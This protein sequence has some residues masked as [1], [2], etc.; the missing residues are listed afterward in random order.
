[1]RFYLLAAALAWTLVAA[2][3][4]RA[5]DVAVAGPS[6]VDVSAFIRDD[7]IGALKLSPDGRFYAATIPGEGR[8]VLAIVR[9]EDHHAIGMFSLGEN[10][11]VHDFHWV[12]PTRVVISMAEKIGL[13][14]Q[15]RLTGN[16]YAMDADGDDP[17]IL[18]GQD[19]QEMSAGSRIRRKET[20]H[21]AAFLLDD[22]PDDDRNVLIEVSG[23][24]GDSHSRVEKM[25]VYSGHRQRVTSGPVINASYFTDRDGIVRFVAGSDVENSNKLYHHAGE[26]AEW[27]L[28]NDESVSGLVAWPL[29]F[30]ADGKIAYLQAER[31]GGPDAI[32]AFDPATG[33]RTQ[34]FRDD[35]TGPM[36]VIRGAR[37][38]PI[39]VLLPDGR[40]RSVFFDPE[41]EDAIL[42]RSLEKA[43]E[44]STVRV[45]SRTA[46]G[47]LLLVEVTNDRNPG[48]FYLYDTVAKQASYMISRRD[49]LDPAAM[50]SM[51]PV[52]LQAR[53]GLSLHGYLT[54][55]AGSDGKDL[56][57]V[58]MPH[59]GPFGV[60]DTWGFDPRV[61]MLAAAGYGVLQV[62]FRGS[63]FR[64]RD[65]AEAGAQQ[66]GRAMQDDITDATR[67]AIAQGIADGDR[68]CIFGASYGAYA[69]LMGVAR[70]PALYQCAIG[71]VGVY[72]LPLMYG[73]GDIRELE[74]GMAFLRDWVGERDG[75]AAVS[76]VHLAGR[77]EVPVF[78]A[79]GGEDER[80]PIEHSHRMERALRKAGVPVETLYYDTEGHGF[81]IDAHRLEFNKRVLAFLDRHVGARSAATPAAAGAGSAP[82]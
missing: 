14:D 13:L 64:G 40:T 8:S 2:S 42:V 4:S 10:S 19:V 1:M 60:A 73:Q 67:W 71:Y 52:K 54:V 51:R 81:H 44:G 75:L 29:G 39:G 17:E 5:A 31:P 16:L 20:E 32:V 76:P 15:P 22:L 37:D 23:F 12:N 38:V 74:S 56:P 79:A 62:N 61:Q 24:A 35:D 48:D 55:P 18:V 47:R 63:T 27:T 30:S 50:A 65:F 33:E 82:D 68:I 36:A 28:V 77:V 69:A 43:F 59:G 9:R 57:L 80:A 26:N 7:A 53:D 3:P 58:V 70:E 21:V 66:W 45:T 6:S 11:Y 41:S 78:L 72:D 34:V 46:D 49:W 25:D